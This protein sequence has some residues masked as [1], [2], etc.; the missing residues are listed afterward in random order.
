MV[1]RVDIAWVGSSKK[2]YKGFP[3]EVQD[4]M[5]FALDCV[6]CGATPAIAKPLKGLGSGIYELVDNYNSDTYRAVY[7]VKFEGIVY[8]LHAFQKKS[9]KGIATPKKE[10]GLIKVRLKA[11]TEHF[12]KEIKKK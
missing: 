3:D 6:Q 2:D 7:A 11:A 12:E 4:V 9:K 5:G 1:D 10:I 8:V